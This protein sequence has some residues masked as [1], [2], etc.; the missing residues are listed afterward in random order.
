MSAPCRPWYLVVV[1]SPGTLTAIGSYRIER[2]IG[3]GGMGVVYLA[4]DTKLERD[5][6]IKAMSARFTDD[7]VKLTRFEREARLLASLNHPNIAAIYAL[8]EHEGARYLVLEF[9][10]GPML[11]DILKDQGASSP[12]RPPPRAGRT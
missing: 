11:K 3:R 1:A 9:V 8:E 6:A 4:R 10:D 12:R 5:V 7:P 2:E